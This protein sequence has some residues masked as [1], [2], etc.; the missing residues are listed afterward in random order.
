M[1][2]QELDDKLQ[3]LRKKLDDN[4]VDSVKA[5]QNDD[6][7]EMIVGLSKEIQDVDQEKAKDNTL[8]TL[9]T[10][11]SDLEGGYRDKKKFVDQK[12]Q[13]VLLTLQERGNL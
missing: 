3:T 7:R 2:A 1:D 5:K 11:K 8:K 12:R 6:L 4:F 13:Y 9:R 10:Q